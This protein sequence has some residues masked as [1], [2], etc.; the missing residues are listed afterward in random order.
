MPPGPEIL[1]LAPAFPQLPGP[2]T[3]LSPAGALTVL[4]FLLGLLLLVGGAELLV[5]GASALATAAGIA[6]LVVGLTVVAFGTSAPELAVTFAATLRGEP[7]LAVGNVVG[8][9]I[10]NILLILGLSALVAPL[11]VQRS[12]VR[13]EVP[14]LVGVSAAVYLMAGNG[15]V[16]RAEGLLLVLTGATYTALLARH[17]VR[18]AAEP[19]AGEAQAPMDGGA[20]TTAGRS[21]RLRSVTANAG[22]VL[23]GLLLLVLGSHWLVD[24]ARAFAAALGV[25]ELVIGL[26]IVAVG[27]S[28]PELATSLVAALRGARDL[29][30][31]NIVGSNLFNLLF[32]L[33][34]AAM[35]SPAGVPV[36]PAARAFDIPV[37][38]AVAAACLPIFFTGHRI[39]RREGALFL[40]YF[41]AYVAYVLL[42]A[43]GHE[44]VVPLRTA[45][46]F[47]AFPL[48]VVM[49]GAVVLRELRSGR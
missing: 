24:S 20:F 23:T 45:M 11:V 30:V 9:N 8:S 14:L 15:H 47:F 16:G 34:G 42:A 21:G 40:G 18:A 1:A 26:T 36:P 13:V 22:F 35:I 19:M 4:L 44:A 48:T 39:G 43:A 32:I 10:S 28:L 29:A 17:A 37:M 31:G 49:L 12:L 41:L 27:T 3:N 25:S 33:G 2:R 7:D 6:P 38:V 5:R 46:I